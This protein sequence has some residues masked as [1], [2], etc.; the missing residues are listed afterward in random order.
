MIMN[1]I[2]RTEHIFQNKGIDYLILMQYN[3]ARKA[4]TEMVNKERSVI[5]R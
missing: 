1:L 5:I 2:I 3:T 4:L